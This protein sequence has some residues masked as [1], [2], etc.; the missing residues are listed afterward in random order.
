MKERHIQ[1]D[2]SEYKPA[3]AIEVPEKR[4]FTGDLLMA[5]TRKSKGKGCRKPLKALKQHQTRMKKR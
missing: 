4:L 5:D 1:G 2:S 3:E